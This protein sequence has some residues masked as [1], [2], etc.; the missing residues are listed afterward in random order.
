MGQA[1]GAPG[2]Q[3]PARRPGGHLL[4]LCSFTSMD[5]NA[6]ACH[7]PQE[8]HIKAATGWAPPWCTGSEC[9]S[10]CVQGAKPAA[11]RQLKKEPA[12]AAKKPPLKRKLAKEG[13]KG[14]AAKMAAAVVESSSS[15]KDDGPLLQRAAPAHAAAAGRAAAG[16]KTAAATTRTMCHWRCGRPQRLRS[17]SAR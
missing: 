2:G 8:L 1:A 12:A 14:P 9:L 13:A 6:P 15:G 4:L 5:V 3:A 10:A 11:S 7:G 17:A 16:L